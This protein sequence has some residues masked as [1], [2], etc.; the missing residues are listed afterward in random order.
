[1]GRLAF[2]FVGALSL[3]LT[4]GSAWGGDTALFQSQLDD[5]LGQYRDAYIHSGR[6]MDP[7]AAREAMSAFTAAWKGLQARW[8]A[9]PP[10]SYSEDPSF[11][12][13]LQAIADIASQAQSQ[14]TAGAV[15]QAHMTLGQIRALLAE[16]RRRNG[17]HG[18]ADEMDAFDDR[19]AEAGDSL[20]DDAQLTPDQSGQLLE[21]CA[22]LAYLGERLEKQAP[23]ALFDDANFLEMAEELNRQV[24][25][26]QATAASGARDPVMASLADLRRNFNRMWLLYGG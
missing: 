20:F 17:L 3:C 26:L 2:L 23:P 7:S 24:R 1:M 8:A 5:A 16:M 21:Q 10:P 12:D 9:A 11:A 15:D 13:E 22:V 19:L 14:T 25:G 6:Q 4:S 18:F